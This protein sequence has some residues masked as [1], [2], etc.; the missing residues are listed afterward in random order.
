MIYYS[1]IHSHMTYGILL[2]GFKNISRL[3]HVQKKSLRI[4]SNTHYF[5]HTAPI[6]KRLNIV[7]LEDVVIDIEFDVFLLFVSIDKSF[8]SSVL[9]LSNV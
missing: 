5:A 4:I 8:A 7:L 6:C 3:Q 9:R 2:W 1:L